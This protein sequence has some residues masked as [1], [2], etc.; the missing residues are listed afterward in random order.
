M[1][2]QIQC[3]TP[4]KGRVL[5]ITVL[6]ECGVPLCGDDEG[7]GQIVASGFTQVAQSAQYDTGA[8]HIV[9][10]ADADLCVNEKDPDA[11]KRMDITIDFCVAHPGIVANT[12]TP[13][14][15]LMTNTT[16]TGFALAEGTGRQRF[17][18]EVWQRVSGAGACDPAGQQLFVYNAWANLGN[19][20]IGDYNVQVEP[21]VLQVMAESAAVSPLWWLGEPWLG[22]GTVS[23]VPDHWFQNVT[24]VA[25]P[26]APT[27][28]V[29]AD[30]PCPVS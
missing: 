1:A 10:T 11:L 26:T 22:E 9:R 17:S 4:I 30:V 27:D 7:Q 18:L 19:G 13:S 14:R 5:R 3:Y 6:D 20:K 23:P 28:C 8:E 15:L 25:P 24:T 12:V 21:S 29:I 2:T 16:G